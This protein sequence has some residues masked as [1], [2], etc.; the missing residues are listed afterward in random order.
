MYKSCIW[1][2]F[3]VFTCILC[4]FCTFCIFCVIPSKHTSLKWLRQSRAA[5]WDFLRLQSK[6]L[7][8]RELK[9]RKN[10]KTKRVNTKCWVACFSTLWANLQLLPRKNE[11]RLAADV[12]YK[13]V[14]RSW[15]GG[16]L[17]ENKLRLRKK[18]VHPFQVRILSVQNCNKA[19][20]L[21]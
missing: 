5:L 13:V 19:K 7:K 18:R 2:C 17:R 15:E 21:V 9:T 8:S 12:E 20:F 16:R 11:T 4:I 10:P 6:E 14:R 1:F 3:F